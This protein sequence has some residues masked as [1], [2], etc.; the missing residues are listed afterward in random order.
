MI[1]QPQP[2]GRYV[3]TDLHEAGGVPVVMSE[4]IA[5]RPRRRRRAG[6]RGRD[7]GRA[8]A[9]PPSPT[10]RVVPRRGAVQASSGLRA[11]RQP[12]AR[13]RGRQGRRAPSAAR[14]TGPARVFDCEDACIAAIAAGA[15]VARRR[16]GHPQ[17]RPRRRPGHARDAEHHRR[18]RR[19]RAR[20]IGHAGHRRAL[21]RRHP[22]ADG[23][24]RRP[25]GRAR[26]AAR[27]RRARA[28]GSRSTSTPACSRVDVARRRARP[29]A[30]R[31]RAAARRASTRGVLARYAGSSAPPPTAPRS[32]DPMSAQVRSPCASVAPTGRSPSAPLRAPTRPA[33]HRRRA[34]ARRRADGLRDRAHRP[35][36]G[37]ARVPL[38]LAALRGQRQGASPDILD[39][40]E[41]RAGVHVGR[42]HGEAAA[43]L[44]LHGDGDVRDAGEARARPVGLGADRRPRIPTTAR[45]ACGS[46]AASSPR[47]PTSSASA[48]KRRRRCRTS[49]RTSGSR[50]GSRRRWSRSSARPS[51]SATRCARRCTSSIPRR[52][53]RRSRSRRTPARTCRSSTTGAEEGRQHAPREPR[54]DREG[55]H[56]RASCKARTKTTIA[57]NKFIVLL[58]RRQAAAGLDRLDQRHRGRHLRPRERRAPRSPTGAS[59]R[60]YLD[61]WEALQG[62]PERK[63]LK[64]FN[65]PPP[66][67]PEAAGRA[68]TRTAIFSPRTQLDPL[69]WYCRLANSREERRLPHRR[70]RAHGRDRTGLRGQ[71]RLPALPAARPRDRQRRGGPPRPGRTSSPPAGFKA[72]G[73][74]RQLD[75]EGP[76]EPQR[77]RRLRAHEVHARRPARRR[78]DRRHRLGELERRVGQA[79]TTRT[80]SSSAATRASP[81]ST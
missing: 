24:P 76:D 32:C 52:C 65:D 8:A 15:I 78:P 11:A 39:A 69:E 67:V 68:H 7:A 66:T 18:R 20:R 27:R 41:P 55:R 36:R 35:H 74:W 53:S 77:P 10:A 60:R 42:L 80:C 34:G 31:L 79:T 50:A 51:T 75:R 23:R 38:Q 57:H 28:S 64:A 81:T 1:A 54:R 16:P 19:R 4:L 9:P 6:G 30:R 26:R 59:R 33:R 45:T 13:R 3:A 48:P 29:P 14:H 25:R 44:H 47:G 61:Y 22:R 56:R 17:R 21:L 2:G 71:T 12:R 5:R 58:A 72:K 49:R 70:V 37:R 62:H 73:G 43:R 40:A 46:T 63:T